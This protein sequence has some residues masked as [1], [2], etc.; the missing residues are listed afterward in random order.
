MKN[1]TAG[2][3]KQ[4]KVVEWLKNK[5]WEI[6]YDGGRGPADI[7]ARLEG[8]KWFIQVKYTRKSEMDESR[9][10]KEK[11]DLIKM[12]DENSGTAIFCYV[13]QKSIWFDSAKTGKTLK[14]G[15]LA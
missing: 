4:E 8:K 14:R 12:A 5:G 7:I 10:S 13:I 15:R 3:R 6:I 11:E 2:Y 1:T 9:F